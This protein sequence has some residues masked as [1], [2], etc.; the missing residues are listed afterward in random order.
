MAA[1]PGPRGSRAHH[2]LLVKKE[3]G[4]KGVGGQTPMKVDVSGDEVMVNM[5]V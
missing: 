3:P 5:S 1:A 4:T 2:I